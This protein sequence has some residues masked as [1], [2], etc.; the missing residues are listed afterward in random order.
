VQDLFTPP[1]Q[2]ILSL[3][4]DNEDV[5]KSKPKGHTMNTLPF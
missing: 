3:G 1:K 2:R 4:E 5:N